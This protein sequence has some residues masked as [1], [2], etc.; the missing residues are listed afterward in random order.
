MVKALCNTL[1]EKD[2]SIHVCASPLLDVFA[3]CLI[4]MDVFNANI[5]NQQLLRVALHNYLVKT[6]PA[7][8]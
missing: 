5:I 7:T 1:A 6:A 3:F 8:V 4:I 2:C